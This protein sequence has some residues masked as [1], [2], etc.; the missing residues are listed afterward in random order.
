M[1]ARRITE[2]SVNVRVT[3]VRHRCYRALSRKRGLGNVNNP[4]V[5]MDVLMSTLL[6]VIRILYRFAGVLT[7]DT[8]CTR[9]EAQ[10]RTGTT[11]E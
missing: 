3:V 8:D 5:P 4:S 1:A 10:G 9:Q 6:V 7:R 2:Q 11:H